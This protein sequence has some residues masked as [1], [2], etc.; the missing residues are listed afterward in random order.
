MD[1]KVR[2]LAEIEAQLK[3]LGSKTGTKILRRAMLTANAPIIDRAKSN[4]AAIRGGSGALRESIGQRFFAGKSSTN[5]LNLPNMGGRFTVQ[6]APLRKNKTATALYNLYYKRKR[7]VKGIRHGHLIEFGHR[8]VTRN[9]QTRGSVA[10][11]PFMAPAAQQGGNVAV[12]ILAREL[13]TGIARQL[14]KNAKRP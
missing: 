11:Q 13:E 12:A 2:G 4:A 6:T 5:E 14:K 3:E 9:G 8:I 10:P 1:I 7:P